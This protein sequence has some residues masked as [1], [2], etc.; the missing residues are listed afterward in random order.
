MGAIP[1]TTVLLG[2]RE[3]ILL[4]WLHPLCLHART[5]A[6]VLELRRL[7]PQEGQEEGHSIVLT[8]AHHTFY[9]CFRILT[10][11]KDGGQVLLLFISGSD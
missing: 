5:L 2:S 8:G 10:E 3:R 7:L 1:G 11:F 4:V 6:G 9:Q